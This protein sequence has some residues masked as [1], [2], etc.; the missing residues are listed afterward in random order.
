MD[1]SARRQ[2]RRA[3]WLLTLGAALGLCAA[4]LGLLRSE[5][6]VSLPADAVA[7]VGDTLILRDDFLRLVAGFEQDTRAPSD[8]EIRRQILERMI[9]EELMVERALDLGLGRLDR[10]GRADLTASLISSIVSEVEGR[11]PSESELRTYYAENDAY[12]TT[13]GRL[14][15]RQIFVRGD[16]EASRESAGATPSG[17]SSARERA[18]EIR[19][20]LEA[21]E[22]WESI[23]EQLGDREIS[24]IPNSMLPPQKLREYVGPT[25]LEQILALDVGVVSE[26][27]ASGS[28]LHVVEVLEKTPASTP[29]FESVRAQ[30][31]ADWRRR[32]GDA[33]L[34]SYIDGLRANADVTIADD[35]GP[36]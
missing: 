11:E 10:R 28:G 23:A 24:P 2:E 3:T 21:G 30:V 14:R 20:R 32:Q 5:P 8:D 29:A 25:A 16:A 15:V 4:A 17:P 34:R 1:E 7:R 26:P 36:Q 19:R 12:F 31:E 6:E 13:P 9:E 18:Q 27:I 22:P 33:A 35:L